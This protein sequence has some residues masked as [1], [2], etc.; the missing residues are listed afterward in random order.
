[1][2]NISFIIPAFNCAETIGE[3]IDSIYDGN[4]SNGDEVI[5]IRFKI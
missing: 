4:F 1:M 2:Q 3:T 5:I